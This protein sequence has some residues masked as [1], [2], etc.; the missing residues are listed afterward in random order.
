MFCT[1]P[2]SW[3]CGNFL[4]VLRC[5]TAMGVD[6]GRGQGGQ[7]PPEFG[8][9][10]AN[11]NCP[12]PRFCHMSTKISV[13]WPSNTPKFVFPGP[14]WGAHNAPADPL[15]GWRGDTPPHIPPHSAPTHLRRS[16]CVPPSEVQPDLLPMLTAVSEVWTFLDGHLHVFPEQLQV[17]L[18]LRDSYCSA[19]DLSSS[20]IRINLIRWQEQLLACV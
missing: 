6:H 7:V 5:L 19:E 1:Y 18:W 9:G 17:V 14:R 2:A 20:T 15:V 11:A 8:A 16:P 10:D 13:L 3:D 4:L 12:P